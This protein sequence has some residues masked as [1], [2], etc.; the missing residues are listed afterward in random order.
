MSPSMSPK[1]CLLMSVCAVIGL[2]T[3]SCKSLTQAGIADSER[4]ILLSLDEKGRFAEFAL[5]GTT[6]PL[7]S[8]GGFSVLEQENAS[9]EK[10]AVVYQSGLGTDET[11]WQPKAYAY[12]RESVS[13]RR[14]QENGIS[15]MRL[16]EGEAF[17]HGVM[18]ERIQVQ[19]FDLC[20]IIWRGRTP[21][22]GSTFIVYLKFFDAQGNDVTTAK[23]ASGVWNVSP[24][25]L[26]HC[27]YGISLESAGQWQ[28]KALEFQIPEGVTSCE[29]AVCLW[30]GQYVDIASLVI[31]KTGSI[32]TRE[33]QFDLCENVPLSRGQGLRLTS[34]EGKLV[35]E[36]AFLEQPDSICIETVLR[37]ISQPPRPRGMT[38]AFHL[39]IS[40]EGWHWNRDWRTDTVIE[41]QASH[42]NAQT[43]CSHP[44]SNYPFTS[45]AR[46][47]Q[48]LAFGCPPGSVAMEYRTTGADGI[49]SYTAL[50]LWPPKNGEKM[51]EARMSFV[52]FPFQGQWGFRS[53]A[54][55]YYRLFPDAF[56]PRTTPDQEG[57]WLWP[58]NPAALPPQAE[59]FGLAFWE[60]WSDDPQ[61]RKRAREL[62]IFIFPYTEAWGLRRSYPKS[63]DRT[64]PSVADRLAELK[65]WAE[66][67]S[68]TETWHGVP[69]NLAARAVL[70]SLPVQPDGTHPFSVDKYG[71]WNHWWFTNANPELPRPNAGT[72][73]WDRRIGPRFDE[74][75]GI[76]LDSLAPQTANYLNVCPDHLDVALRPLCYSPK[77]GHPAA[78]GLSHQ[79]AY[80]QWLRH[81]FEG[82]NKLIHGNLFSVSHRF[83]S[84]L[85]DVFGREVGTFGKPENRNLSTPLADEDAGVQ[86]F[87]A[88]HRPV[89]NL[90]QEGNYNQP[91]PE[92]THEQV[93]QYAENHLFYG[94]Y[95][96]I[97]TIGGEEKPG[98]ANWKRYYGSYNGKPAQAERDRALYK[99]V[100]PL[101]RRLNQ[102]GWKPETGMRAAPSCV[103]VE[104][105]GG[106]S[107]KETL[108]T[109]RNNNDEKV[110]AR[111]T[112]DSTLQNSPTHPLVPIQLATMRSSQC[113]V[114]VPGVTGAFD[115]L[116]EPW[117]TVVLKMNDGRE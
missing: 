105:F 39:P 83:H 26:T 5:Y 31:Q 25:S 82:T 28:E 59:D 41:P 64:M 109:V 107:A 62:G 91:V 85:I 79:V 88:Y 81:R 17:G 76:Y 77:T 12:T 19:P 90:L 44:V 4:S 99:E 52:L 57:L 102:A 49:T 115:L 32:R 66:E 69:R 71:T 51:P 111:L 70:N 84:S 11:N 106:D 9:L 23:T 101:I 61:T 78:T 80:I 35:L 63:E 1:Q 56:R 50:G 33:I 68:T 34:R 24:Y 94:F 108:F 43:V 27:L 65:A 54:K 60:G 95:P 113:P 14:M 2:L 89:S 97:S 93:R 114:P 55:V 112:L 30:R 3:T 103:F 22:T 42:I 40:L 20:Q 98:Y 110:Q 45:V 10:P 47:G 100:V 29:A 13:V 75:D 96:A 21:D 7:I 117:Q 18:T 37:D 58:I 67:E 48:G 6:L 15:F 116:L 92:L 86:R 74:M 73:S 72:L 38:L 104:R 46:T 53:A 16:G 87:Y 8:P 36:A